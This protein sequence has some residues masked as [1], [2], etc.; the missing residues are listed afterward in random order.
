MV[1]FAW[2]APVGRVIFFAAG[3][4]LKASALAAAA[5]GYAFPT[6]PSVFLL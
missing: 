3:S 5:I 6:V 4:Y 2:K 1:S